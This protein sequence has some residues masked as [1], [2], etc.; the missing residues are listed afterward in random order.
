MPLTRQQ[1]IRLIFQCGGEFLR[2]GAKH[3]IYVS[4]SGEEIQIPRHRKDLS[5]GVE[6]DLK[7]KLGLIP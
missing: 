2:H 5:Y 1:A 7:K 3:D 4:A 6:R